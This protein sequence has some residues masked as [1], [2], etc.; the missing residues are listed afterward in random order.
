MIKSFK[1][2]ENLIKGSYIIKCNWCDKWFF[3]NEYYTDYN[4]DG[5]EMCPF[6]NYAGSLMNIDFE[7]IGGKNFKKYIENNPPKINLKNEWRRRDPIGFFK[8]AY[9]EFFDYEKYNLI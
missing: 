3:D 1:I 6:C 9:P 5:D 4:K 7:E 2:F 8:A